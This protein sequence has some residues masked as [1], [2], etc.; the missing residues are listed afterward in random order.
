MAANLILITPSLAWEKEQKRRRA[1]RVEPDIANQ[2]IPHVGIASLAAVAKQHGIHFRILDMV[3]DGL[4]IDD[5]VAIVAKERPLL[6]GLSAFTT[7]IKAAAAVAEAIHRVVDDVAIG[8]GGPHAIAMP[9]KTLAEFPVFDFAAC[10]EGELLLPL[11]MERLDHRHSLEGLPGVVTRKTPVRTPAL[12]T[13]LETMPFPA[14][15]EFNLA[16]F[17]GVYPHRTRLELPLSTGR[18]C[19][20]RCS[21][22]AR[23]LGDTNRRRSVASVI[24]EIEHNVEAY[25]CES[26]AFLD[27][28]FILSKRWTEE[29][30]T[31][32]RRRGLHQKITWS[33]STRVTGV[34]PPLFQELRQA[35]CY[36]IFFGMESADD[37]TLKRIH[38]N[39]KVRDIKSAVH[40]AKLAGIVPVGAFIIGLPGE[41]EEDV[42][43][44]INL[45]EELDLYSVTFPIAVPFPGTELREMALRGEYGLR[46]IS[47]DWNDYGKQGV[48]VLDSEGFPWEQR[49]SMQ[50]LAYERHPKK[51]MDDYLSRLRN[52]GGEICQ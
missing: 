34:S 9:G 46:I 26:I 28:T 22:C 1:M 19:P 41:R 50:R 3:T 27:E 12:L 42:L 35:G 7:Q 21:F 43:L 49:K 24:A 30:L 47:H 39:I 20:Y 33:C 11:L 37:Q 13:D 29:F 16:K 5:V 18:G 44:A 2:E 17:G 4:S 15:S 40:G 23:A 31:V 8:I 14:W 6:V 48:G 25:G 38:K 45:A 32:M 10:G 52:Y 36:Y 51:R